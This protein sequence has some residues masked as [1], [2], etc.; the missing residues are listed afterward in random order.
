MKVDKWIIN[1]FFE[2]LHLNMN[3][4]ERYLLRVGDD[5]AQALFEKMSISLFATMK[6]LREYLVVPYDPN[7]IEK[8]TEPIDRT[9]Q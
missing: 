7:N 2:V 4:L 5:K 1:Y 6:E 3:S 9:L 8:E